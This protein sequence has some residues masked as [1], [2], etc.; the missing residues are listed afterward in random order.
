[1]SVAMMKPSRFRAILKDLGWTQRRA[2]SELGVTEGA[3]SRW[4][5]ATRPI[6]GPVAFLVRMKHQTRKRKA[7]K[8][9]AKDA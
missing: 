3:V 2:A 8:K 1:M 4:V 5:A 9:E 7:K 6:P